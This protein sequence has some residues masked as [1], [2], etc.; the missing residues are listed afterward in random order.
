MSDDRA[1][2][3]PHPRC[4]ICGKPRN[5]RFRPF[6]SAH[7]RDF[8]LLHWLDGTYTIPAVDREPDDDESRAEER[9]RP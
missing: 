7:C 8:D 1:G 5:Q 3:R 9:T 6:C 2:P 4:P